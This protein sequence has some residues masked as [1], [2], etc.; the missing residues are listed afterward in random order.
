[1]KENLT[2]TKNQPQDEQ[3]LANLRLEAFKTL[4]VDGRDI[5]TS[6]KQA[7]TLTA[8]LVGQAPSTT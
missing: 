3:W 6:I 5:E 1:M 4:H 8:F 7:T 2:E